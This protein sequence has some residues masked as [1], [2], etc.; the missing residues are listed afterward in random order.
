MIIYGKDYQSLHKKGRRKLTLWGSVNE[1]CAVVKTAT[2][3][4]FEI[5]KVV[6]TTLWK[7]TNW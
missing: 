7:Q 5:P 4:S 1:S 6:S 3:L 2:A